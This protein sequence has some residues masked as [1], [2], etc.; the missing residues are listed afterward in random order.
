MA[1]EPSR[2]GLNRHARNNRRAV[3]SGVFW[4]GCADS[5]Q[6]EESKREC[7]SSQLRFAEACIWG[8]GQFGNPEEGERPPLEAVT[9]QR[10]EDCDW[11]H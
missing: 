5:V 7:A 1:Q 11:E 3:G 9:K 2:E 6:V 10:S 8:P 4:V